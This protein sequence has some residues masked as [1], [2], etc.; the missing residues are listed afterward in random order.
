MVQDVHRRF[1]E[2]LAISLSSA[3]GGEPPNTLTQEEK[4]AVFGRRPTVKELCK[5]LK[6]GSYKD[7]I[8][9]AGAG[10]SVAAGIPDFRSPGSGLYDSLDLKRYGI[11][12]PQ[13]IF[14][15]EFF[16]KNPEPFF[17]V[18]KELFLGDKKYQ[19][20]PAHHFIRL[21]AEKKILLRCYTQVSNYGWS[22]FYV[23]LHQSFFMYML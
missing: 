18:R 23:D 16:R 2:A 1:G 9:M 6:A 17:K 5:R 3:F 11:P 14:D 12:S 13:A 4:E 10:I 21:L 7:I 15:I 22:R 8:V 20:T 19:P